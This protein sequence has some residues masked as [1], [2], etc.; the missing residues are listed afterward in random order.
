MSFEASDESKAQLVD[1]R[2][3]FSDDWLGDPSELS[4]ASL[5]G[6]PQPRD[7]VENRPVTPSRATTVENIRKR[8]RHNVLLALVVTLIVQT[9]QGVWGYAVLGPY[10]ENLTHSNSKVGFVSFHT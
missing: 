6:R 5:Q 7:A 2:I 3:A 10:I 8:A 1:Q 9:S 4:A